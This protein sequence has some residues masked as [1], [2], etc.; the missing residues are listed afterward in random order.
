VPRLLALLAALAL[1]A[2]FALW[3]PPAPPALPAVANVTPAPM[4]A[5]AILPPAGK[6]VAS[7]VY[8]PQPPYGAAA[9]ITYLIDETAEQFAA[10]YR[11]QLAAAGYTIRP[12][13][14]QFSVAFDEPDLQLEA[15]E[16]GGSAGPAPLAGRIGGVWSGHVIYLALR[17][18]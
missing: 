16:Q 11:A 9:T 8:P 2:A 5:W 6:V 17:H 13:P 14:P 1:V 10:A 4:P 12:I 15:D 3:S 7:G 18:T